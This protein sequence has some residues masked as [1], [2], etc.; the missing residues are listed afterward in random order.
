MKRR[1]FFAIYAEAKKVK[2]LS[3][4]QFL[5]EIT[6]RSEETTIVIV[7]VTYNYILR[8]KNIKLEQFLAYNKITAYLIK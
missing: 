4:K 5:I 2:Y 6:M 8:F 1:R 7:I 3:I